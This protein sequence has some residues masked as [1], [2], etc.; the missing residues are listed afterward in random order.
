[1]TAPAFGGQFM[2]ID[3][4]EP[5]GRV[6]PR[7]Y[8]RL[9][10]V[11][12]GLRPY[13][14]A[15][16]GRL[17]TDVGVYWSPAARVTVEPGGHALDQLPPGAP[18]GPAD[19]HWLAV[20]G[21]LGALNEAHLAAGAVSRADLGRLEELPLLVLPALTRVDEDEVRAIREYVAGGGRLYASGASSLL[22]TDGT[23]D[24]D[25]LLADVFGCHL[26]GEAEEEVTYLKPASAELSAALG[27]LEYVALGEP[28]EL[29]RAYRPVPPPSV[30]KVAAAQD[31]EVLMTLTVPYAGGRGTRDDQDWASIH[32]SPP[33]EDTTRPAVLRHR[34]GDGEVIYSTVDLEG[35]RGR[36]ADGSRRLFVELVR[37]LLGRAPTFE[38]DAHPHA[39]TTVFH[40]PERARFR[41]AF[42]NAPAEAP[43]L[44]IPRI[45]FRLRAPE[46][47]RF[48]SL[49]RLPGG[50]EVGFALDGEGAM[51]AEV[52]D[53]ELFEMLSATYEEDR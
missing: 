10:E 34:F 27:P 11:F 20:Q 47:A 44:P 14:T 4:V 3:A 46:G 16:G 7:T 36:L 17:L 19:P 32:S 12:D 52:R 28:S 30:L 49:R 53:L 38:A 26:R 18:M 2:A 21:G 25:F 35:A 37:L 51:R 22:S 1:M 33:W 24:D 9:R 41:L 31:A 48:A 43:P 42:L 5:D 29:E 23:P 8:E 45:A 6:N 39:W 13:E 50:E 15:R 40:E